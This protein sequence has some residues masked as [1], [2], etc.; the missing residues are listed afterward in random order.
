MGVAL[1]VVQVIVEFLHFQPV[2]DALGFED[3]V[4]LQQQVGQQAIVGGDGVGE[5]LLE[6]SFQAA[7]V[8][9][10]GLPHLHASFEENNRRFRLILAVGQL[11][12]F[13]KN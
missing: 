6:V 10:N 9:P 12:G 11:T 4:L 13:T 7:N 8:A 2:E 1:H 5:G 3:A